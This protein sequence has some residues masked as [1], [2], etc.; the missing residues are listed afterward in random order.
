M[1][2]WVKNVVKVKEWSDWNRSKSFALYLKELFTNLL[3]VKN[4]EE[5]PPKPFVEVVDQYQLKDADLLQQAKVFR[6][7]FHIFLTV[8]LLI[9]MYAFF[10]LISGYWMI[11]LVI[12][13]ISLIAFSLAFRYHFYLTSLEN[14]RLNLTI[15][16]WFTLTFKRK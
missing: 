6:S 1:F 16:D 14:K 2:K 10:K 7:L 8:F 12:L 4:I 13:C 11:G 15:H 3:E 9:F 5:V